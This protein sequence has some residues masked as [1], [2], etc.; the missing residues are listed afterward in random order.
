MSRIRIVAYQ[1]PGP[2][3]RTW[4]GGERQRFT[5]GAQATA[6]IP[7]VGRDGRPPRHISRLMGRVGVARGEVQ[8]ENLSRSHGLVTRRWGHGAA[9]DHELPARREGPVVQTLSTGLWWVRNGAQ[10]TDSG[11][12]RLPFDDET[13]WLLVQ[14]V[15]A[16]GD[17]AAWPDSGAVPGTIMTGTLA[18]GPRPDEERRLP[19]A[20]REAL[21]LIF[22]EFLSFPPRVAPAPKSD[23]ELRERH[24]RDFS[25]RRSEIR[26]FAIEAGYAGQHVDGEL[27]AWLIAAEHL[28]PGEVAGYP[29]G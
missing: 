18:A 3:R 9:A 24:G 8:L 21:G 15:R 19:P 16:D 20:A 27:L 28:L 7:L 12:V 6:S 1:S 25:Q 29:W 26:R 14:V 10:R 4:T 22:D 13:C 11:T 17:Q 2:H 5:F 23:R